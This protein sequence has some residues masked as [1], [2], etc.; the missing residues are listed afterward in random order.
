VATPGA[1]VTWLPVVADVDDDEL[2]CQ[3]IAQ[4]QNGSVTVESD[5][6]AGE[7]SAGVAGVYIFTY[8]V[9]DGSLTD[10]AVGSVTVA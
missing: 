10:T 8:E 9:R 7:F 4:P 2:T 6:L 3:I 5:C 1:K